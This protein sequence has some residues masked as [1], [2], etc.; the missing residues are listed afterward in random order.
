MQVSS[1]AFRR[2]IKEVGFL[3]SCHSWQFY[4]KMSEA[5][6]FGAQALSWYFGNLNKRES[7]SLLRNQSV[8]TYL[9]RDSSDPLALYTL[10]VR[11]LYQ[12][13]HIRIYM[14]H[15]QVFYI[16]CNSDAKDTNG[17]P[18]LNGFGSMQE[19]IEYYK[20]HGTACLLDHNSELMKFQLIQPLN[21]QFCLP[22]NGPVVYTG[23]NATSNMLQKLL[24]DC[25]HIRI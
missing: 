18:L 7:A 5:A 21:R 1:Y 15:K 12:I 24:W 16:S 4:W 2:C 8:G 25:C 13:I 9:L 6:S 14:N 23:A 20:T 3:I 17:A 10:S 19:M 22:N 11:G